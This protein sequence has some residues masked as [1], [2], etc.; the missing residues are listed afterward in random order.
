MDKKP[1]ISVI[2]TVYNLEKYI[3]QCILS[4]TAQTY[5]NLQIIIVDDGSTDNSSAICDR[6]AASDSRIEIIHQENTGAAGAKNRGLSQA[7]GKYLGFVDGDDCI[8][9]DMYE[10]LLK[11]CINT[12]A[13]ISVCGR[14]LIDENGKKIKSMF[15]V[16]TLEMYSGKEMVKKIL[17]WDGCDSATWDKLF[18]RYLWN[19][20]SFPDVACDDLRVTVLLLEKAHSVVHIPGAKYYYRQRDNS[21][22]KNPFSDSKFDWY[23]EADEIRKL[24]CKNYPEF[25]REANSFVWHY[26]CAMISQ[27]YEYRPVYKEQYKKLKDIFLGHYPKLLFNKRFIKT[28][29]RTI[30]KLIL[31]AKVK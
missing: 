27:A 2:I 7:R 31:L 16:D 12:N 28:N 20:I 8:A 29:I 30:A 9:P 14:T 3:E 24:V 26:L 23:Y 13:Q 18:E 15:C 1:L 4:V 5:D 19:H 17:A 6:L 25:E 22:T 11:G 10:Q 21:V